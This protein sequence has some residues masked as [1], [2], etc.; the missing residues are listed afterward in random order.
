M[1]PAEYNITIPRGGTFDLPISLSDDDGLVDFSIV[2][3]GARMQVRDDILH[4]PE[5]TVEAALLDLTTENGGL[6]ISGT[7]LYIHLTAAETAAL[8]FVSGKYD[9]ELVNDAGTDDVVDKLL[10]GKVTVTGEV[11]VEVTP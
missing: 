2:Y 5:T 8:T 4:V 10:Y 11:T 6:E 9:I 7:T 1:Q 3:T